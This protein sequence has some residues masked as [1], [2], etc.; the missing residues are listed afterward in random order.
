MVKFIY[1]LLAFFPAVMGYKALIYHGPKACEG[2]PESLAE[3]LSKRSG[4]DIT[5]EFV[6]PTGKVDL[7]PEILKDADIYAYPGGPGQSPQLS[8]ND[9]ETLT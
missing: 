1:P 7:S 3:L 8:A 2:C 9:T 6:G 5:T 4:L